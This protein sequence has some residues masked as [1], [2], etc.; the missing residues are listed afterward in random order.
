MPDTKAEPSVASLLAVIELQNVVASSRL[1]L[2][3]VMRV[4]VERATE[5]TSASGAVVELVDG[6][7]M[8]YRAV[9][10]SASHSLG[11]RLNRNQSLSGL[12][13]QERIS[14]QSNDTEI[15]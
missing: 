9:F 3:S 7:E 11:L 10:G 15:D 6:D 4:V 8:V 5:L 2:D 14:L 1:D 13:V 12:C